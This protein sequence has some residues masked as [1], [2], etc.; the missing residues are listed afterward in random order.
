[1]RRRRD[2]GSRRAARPR[3]IARRACRSCS[4]RRRL[5][6]RGLW[7]AGPRAWND[8]RR[9]PERYINDTSFVAVIKRAR[10]RLT[11][12]SDYSLRML[13]YLGAQDKRLCTI[14]EI[15]QAYGISEN[16]LMKVANRLAQCGFIES[17]RG[18]GGGLRLGKPAE[19]ITLGAVLRAME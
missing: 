19:A 14:A 8:L 1:A 11:V 3:R 18:R 6:H 9:L 13:M 7:D 12:L 5:Q 10:M 15:A 17:V 4:H 2:R 16:H